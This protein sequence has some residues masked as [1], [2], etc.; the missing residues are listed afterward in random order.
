MGQREE[1]ELKRYFRERINRALKEDGFFK[2]SDV[3]YQSIKTSLL[4]NGI[5]E[6][7]IKKIEDDAVF[8]SIRRIDQ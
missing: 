3:W 5:S 2:Y 1:G 4:N 7:E 8:R 6:E